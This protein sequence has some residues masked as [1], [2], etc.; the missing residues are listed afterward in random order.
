MGLSKNWSARVEYLHLDLGT[1]SL[2]NA[3]SGTSNVSVPIKDDIVR[4]GISYH[5]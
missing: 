3:A 4:A 5:W 2:F 1:A